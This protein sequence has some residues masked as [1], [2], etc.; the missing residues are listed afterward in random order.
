MVIADDHPLVRSGLRCA[1]TAP[2]IEIVGEAG[3]GKEAIAV[4]RRLRPDIVILDIQMPELGGLEALTQIKSDCPATAV[5]I[6]TSFADPA[7]LREAIL[8]GA[9]AYLLKAT[10]NDTLLA[11]ARRVAEGDQVLDRD[12][13]EKI[14]R[15]A[16]AGQPPPPG[17]PLSLPEDL[18]PR[19]VQILRGILAGMKNGEIGKALGMSAVTVRSHC[20]HLFSKIGISDR[21]QVMLWAVRRGVEP[22]RK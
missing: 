18:T 14:M 17:K 13:E 6:L 19:E 16:L 3:N 21:T 7:Y 5:I 9:A 4:V 8:G 22:L 2:D 1:L 10:G 20:Y 12:L 15:E 11:T